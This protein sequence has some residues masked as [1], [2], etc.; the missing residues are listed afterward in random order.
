[1]KWDVP[2]GEV[3]HGLA[4][5]HSVVLTLIRMKVMV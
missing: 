4:D 1:L 5:I 3:S 2:V